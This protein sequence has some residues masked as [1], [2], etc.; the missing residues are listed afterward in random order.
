M[1]VGVFCNKTTKKYLPIQNELFKILNEKNITFSVYEK[2]E[3]I[4]DID[5]LIVLG[6]DGTILKVATEMGKKG[7]KI[8]GINSGNLGFLTEFEGDETQNAVSLIENGFKTQT[9]SVLQVEINGKSFYALNEV[10]F[11]R[12]YNEE[13]DNNVV[14]ITAKIDGKKVDNFI[15]DGIIVSTPTGSTAYSLSAGG[16]ILTP[17]IHAFILTPVCTHSLRNRPIV[18]SDNSNLQ[19]QLLDGEGELSA[20]CDGKF[21]CVVSANDTVVIKKATFTV[22]FAESKKSF[23]D[24]LLYKLSKWSN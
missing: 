1:K 15:G 2:V 23:F 4:F 24:K 16:P 17:D 7:I 3:E 14:G 19:I 13:V 9:R 12:R 5:T 6:G 8:L 11:Q 20:F 18:Y 22:E 21:I 10:F